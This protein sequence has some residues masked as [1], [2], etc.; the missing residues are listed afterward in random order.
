MKNITRPALAAGAL[1]AVAAVLTACGPTVSKTPAAPPSVFT[2]APL[3]PSSAPAAPATPDNTGPP[4]TSFTVTTTDDAGNAVVY[5]VTLTKFD[6]HAGLTPYESTSNAADRMAAAR[7]T[8]TGVTGQE[9]DDANN[10]ATV[11]GADTTEYSP[12]FLSVSDGPNFNGGEFSVAPG[13]TVSGW[14]A[15]EVPAGA[16]VATV[17][18]TPGLSGPGATWTLG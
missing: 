3:P 14:V 18:W 12:S 9:S 6:Q 2:P 4:G 16:V 13:Q 10:D 5:T 17:G 1:L 15:F 11:T 7:F 8:V